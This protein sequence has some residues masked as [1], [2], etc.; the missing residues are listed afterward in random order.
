MITVLAKNVQKPL[1]SDLQLFGLES[2]A[3]LLLKTTENS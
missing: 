2:Q 1:P 3:K